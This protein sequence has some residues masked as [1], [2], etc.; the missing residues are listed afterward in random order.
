MCREILPSPS[1]LGYSPVKT[2]D[3]DSTANQSTVELPTVNAATTITIETPHLEP[4]P[5]SFPNLPPPPQPQPIPEQEPDFLSVIVG[6][7]LLVGASVIIYKALGAL[8][9]MMTYGFDPYGPEIRLESVSFSLQNISL[10]KITTRGEITFDITKPHDCS[11]SIYD[12]IVVS[13]FHKEKPLSMTVMEPFTQKEKNTMVKA[14]FPSIVSPIDT[15]VSKRM[16]LYLV[17]NSS[18][19]FS[20]DVKAK[21]RL[22]P[23][24]WMGPEDSDDARWINIWCPDVKVE[25]VAKTGLGTMAGEPMKCEVKAQNRLLF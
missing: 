25:I 11:V 15:R 17:R 4:H 8:T 3:I 7:L 16:A 6:L 20:F 22:W 21:G 24:E 2:S 5:T 23:N 18:F 12:D 10:S 9:Y 14:M 13:I 19:E 1:P